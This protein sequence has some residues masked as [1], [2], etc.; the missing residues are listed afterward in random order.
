MMDVDNKQLN[1]IFMG[2]FSYPEGHASTK[3][4]QNTIQGLH[5]AG[6]AKISVL[7]LRQGRQRLGNSPLCGVHQDI[8]YA[9]IG[10]GIVPG[11]SVL[12]K[13]VRYY[14]EGRKYLKESFRPKMKNIVYV[15]GPPSLDNCF[16]VKQAHRLGYKVVFDIVE[17]VFFQSSSKD[18]FARL[19][20]L[21]AKYY[22]GQ[23]DKLADGILVISTHLMNVV[24]ERVENHNKIM[25][26]PINLYIPVEPEGLAFSSPVTRI[27]Y[28]GT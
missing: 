6:H 8:P 13:A 24:K 15:Y 20:H 14:Y 4:V 21:S 3:R 10:Q 5:L 28:G 2:H 9:T 26:F 18:V 17:D 23:I 22:F 25:H 11:I 1:V 19:K 7:V 16:F 12:W 27:F